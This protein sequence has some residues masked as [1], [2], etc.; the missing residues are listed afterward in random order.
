MRPSP[1]RRTSSRPNPRLA[2]S[3][4]LVGRIV[5]LR[6][7]PEM[8]RV[9][10]QL[11]QAG[12]ALAELAEVAVSGAPITVAL[13]DQVVTAGRRLWTALDSADEIYCSLAH[14]CSFPTGT[15]TLGR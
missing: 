4:A 5:R 6:V 7:V 14:L 8:D 2:S 3:E 15:P 13:G 11:W 9:V 10:D 1:S 12:F